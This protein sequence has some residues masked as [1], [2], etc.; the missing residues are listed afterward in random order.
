MDQ[1]TDVQTPPDGG[2][3]PA[4]GKGMINFLDY[5]PEDVK[6]NPEMMKS[7][8][9]VKDLPG[10]IKSYVHTQKQ[11]GKSINIPGQDAKTEDWDAFYAKIGRPESP[12]KYDIKRPENP[13]LSYDEG[14]E[15]K[16]LS[17]AHK[18]GL[19]KQQAQGLLDWWSSEQETVFQQMQQEVQ[20]SVDELKKEWG[21]AYDTKVAMAQRAIK[22]FGDKNLV[23]FLEDSGLGNNPHLVKFF[24]RLGENIREDRAP[25]GEPVSL[26]SADEAKQK[27]A[28]ITSDRNHVYHNRSKPGHKEAVAEM[29]RLFQIAYGGMQ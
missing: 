4:P 18:A 19:N 8:E 26:V 27:I 20:K 2:Q 22:R 14:L 10:L 6:S 15:K 17:A 5:T 29:E 9:K 3:P 28:A 11:I 24:A 23:G 7:L 25:G 16:F 12:E 13:N 21:G 1:K